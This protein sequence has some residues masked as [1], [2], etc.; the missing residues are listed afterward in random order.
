ME[1]I[2]GQVHLSLFVFVKCIAECEFIIL[3]KI[4]TYVIHFCGGGWSF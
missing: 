2:C 4:T 1:H 3:I